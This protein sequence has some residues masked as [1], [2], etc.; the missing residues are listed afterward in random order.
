[1]CGGTRER[2]ACVVE[3]E[4][5]GH[6]GHGAAARH[7]LGHEPVERGAHEEE[8][9]LHR[10]GRSGEL[11]VH[12]RL[13]LHAGQYGPSCVLG[14]REAPGAQ[15]DVAPAA[16]DVFGREGREQPDRA[17]A[18]GVEGGA[19]LLLHGDEG[20]RRGGEVVCVAAG[21]DHVHQ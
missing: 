5:D 21:G 3:R 2:A 14:T 17:E 4:G 13:R 12:H 10:R 20:E 16:F 18:E 9:G 15:S 7:E 11:H 8:H 19:E 1:M 6:G